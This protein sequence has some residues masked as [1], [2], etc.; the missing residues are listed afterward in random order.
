M[1]WSEMN[2]IQ[3]VVRCIEI[4]SACVLLAVALLHFF[5]VMEI[6]SY[7]SNVII[8]VWLLSTAFLQKNRTSAILY[9]AV[10]GINLLLALLSVLI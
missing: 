3:K 4:V 10:G 5:D 7:V 1:K 6:R 8:G 2:T 9:Y